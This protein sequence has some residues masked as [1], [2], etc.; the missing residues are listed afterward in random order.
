[1]YNYLFDYFDFILF[2]LYYIAE[3]IQVIRWYKYN[4]LYYKHRNEH[5]FK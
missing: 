5:L 3:A 2:Y 1:L 4:L